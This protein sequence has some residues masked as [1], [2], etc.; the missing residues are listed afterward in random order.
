MSVF[1]LGMSGASI[2][3]AVCRL[4]SKGLGLGGWVCRNGWKCVGG[5]IG[6]RAGAPRRGVVIP[7]VSPP[8][9]SEAAPDWLLD[10]RAQVTFGSRAE[11]GRADL[12]AQRRIRDPS[13]LTARP[14]SLQPAPHRPSPSLR[15]LPPEEDPQH[16]YGLLH[17]KLEGLGDGHPDCS[18]ARAPKNTLEGEGE[19]EVDAKT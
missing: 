12:R 14:P 6:A 18:G 16:Q 13:A 1:A 15:Q 3:L 10:R 4:S 2:Y 8:T 5:A 11:R 7:P 9:L 17:R 19:R